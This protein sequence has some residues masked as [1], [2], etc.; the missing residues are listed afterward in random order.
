MA[1]PGPVSEPGA[2][3]GALHRAFYQPLAAKTDYPEEVPAERYARQSSGSEGPL[4]QLLEARLTALGYPCGPGDGVYDYRTKDAVMAFEKVERL[5]RDG[6][7]RPRGWERLF[8]TGTP[9]PR[10]DRAGTGLRSISSARCSS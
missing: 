3:G 9:S 1:L 6:D 2:D 8:S 7:R 4:V 5:K 10:L